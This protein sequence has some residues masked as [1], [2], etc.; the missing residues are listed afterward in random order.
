MLFF[1]A[2]K[3][4]RRGM[5]ITKPGKAT[6]RIVL[7]GRLE[8]CLQLVDGG[9]EFALLG[10]SMAYVGPEVV[11]QLEQLEIDEQKIKRLIILHAHF[12]HCGLIPFL[13]RRWP[14]ATV[15]ASHRAKTLLATPKVSQ[16]IA[17]LNEAAAARADRTEAVKN[18]DA[19]F[20]SIEVE[21]TVGDGDVL[22]CGEATL[23][24]LEVPG[25]SSCSNACFLPEE[26]ALFASDAAGISYEGFFLSSGNSNFD[27]Y[28]KS[29]DRLAALDVEVLVREHYG[30]HIGDDA[31]R[32]LTKAVEDA[33]RTRELLVT[34]F[35]KTGDVSQCTEEVVDI[36]YANAPGG[37]MPREIIAMVV[38]QMV[39]YVAKT[40][41]A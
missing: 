24:F 34:T 16:T 1:A 33:V 35:Q 39:K 19:G 12:D 15:T 11:E 6:D 28:Q 30:I 18:L 21:E 40:L 32:E 8:S 26:K 7:L 10:G 27:L 29:L 41:A 22:Q 13:K 5:H 9:S 14:W 31:R 37:F 2:S 3:P 4:A 36:L 17:F 38:G 20:T 23:E 25:H